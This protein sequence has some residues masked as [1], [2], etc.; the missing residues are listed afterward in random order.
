MADWVILGCGYV[1]TRLAHA[2]LDAGERVRLCARNAGRLQPLADRGAHVHP[3]DAAKL[4]AFG[5]A[6]YGSASP[7][8]IYSVPPL[9]NQPSGEAIRRAAEACTGVGAQR[10]V[11]LSST[12][13]YGETPDGDVVDEQPAFVLG[14]GH[15]CAFPGLHRHP[16]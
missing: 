2:L 7:Y 12:A 3:M 9:P 5:P 13:V 1:G 15:G 10:F 4:R 8:V 6:L 16:H 11:Y 14:L